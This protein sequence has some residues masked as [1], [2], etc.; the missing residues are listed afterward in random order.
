MGVENHIG[1][2]ENLLRDS[3]RISFDQD[4]IRAVT[5]LLYGPLGTF[6]TLDKTRDSSC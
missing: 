4:G 1:T 6:I 3:P 2:D 5:K